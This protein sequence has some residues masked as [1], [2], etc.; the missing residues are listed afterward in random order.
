MRRFITRVGAWPL[1]LVVLI[2]AIGV[3]TAA[4]VAATSTGP[5]PTEILPAPGP[6]GAVAD[7]QIPGNQS[8][9]H[10]PTTFAP[11]PDPLSVTAPGSELG[12]NWAGQT[13]HNQRRDADGGNQLSLEPPDQGLC[14][15]NGELIET[16]NDIVATYN[17]ATGAKTSPVSGF[18]SLNQFYIGDHQVNRSAS[19]VTFG[20]FLS[21][22]RCL[23]DAATGRFFMTILSFARDPLTGAF[24]G[25]SK[26]WIAT[27]KT[28]TPTA[29]PS[30]WNII[31]IDTTN[32]GKNGEA[33]HPGC[34]CFGDQPLVG[35]DANGV[36]VTTNEFPIN[37]PGFNGAQLYAFQKTA[38][39]AG[40]APHIVRIEGD[41][42]ASTGYGAGIPYSLQPTTSP[43]AGDFAG[44][45][46]G[47]EYL[48]GALEFGKK[49]FQLDNRLGLWA[50]TN[51]ASLNSA[52][53]ALKL[54]NTIVSSQTYGFPPSIVQPK[55][56]TPQADALKEHE[57]L[58]D[59]GDDRMQVA[60]Y[61]HGHLWGAS[62]TIVKTPT[63]SSQVGVAY[64]MLSPSVDSAGVPSG[65]VTKQG[66]VSVNGNSVTRP[67]LG[68][69]S[70]G[71]V[72]LG[73]SLIGP[74]YFPSAAYTTFDD[75]ATSAPTTLHV[76]AAG[77]VP[78]DG[79]SG[80]RANGASGIERWGDYGF[81]AAVGNSVWVA[82]EWIPGL[83]QGADLAAWG[84][85]V[86]KITP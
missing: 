5:G 1:A 70:S 48:L 79:F 14:V 57:N 62:D 54:S 74:D 45:D 6:D 67:S 75:G 26:L 3:V 2:G 63:G 15:G 84:T 18:E 20:A 44:S 71:K 53:P 51:T 10:L 66:Y 29:S 47:T 4:A 11:R 31:S 22:P 9:A 46:N 37:G 39:E 78:A 86:S 65:S 68:V 41:P 49:P 73:V 42:I 77:T 85:Y 69:T 59:G 34:P 27:S 12:I 61:A 80:F 72:V 21:D 40:T 56:P 13:F 32:D 36:Y 7:K 25:P 76:A 30:D 16:V 38:L 28:G 23:Y 81:A 35:I 19:P 55:G 24:E 64:Y 50:L 83:N 33:S 8:P 52:T 43:S 82:N 60:V 17:P 58:I